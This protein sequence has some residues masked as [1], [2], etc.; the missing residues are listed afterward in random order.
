MLFHSMHSELHYKLALALVPQIGDVHARIL[1]SHFEDAQSIFS[2]PKEKLEKLEGIGSVRARAI[3]EFRDF[4]KVEKELAFMEQS[5]VRPIFLSDPGYPRRLQQCFDAPA[6]LFYK[7]SADLNA[8]RMVAVVG[9][10]SQTEYGR[11]FTLSLIE[12]LASEEIVVVSG[13]AFGIDATAHRAALDNGLATIGV[14]GHG[15]DKVY[16]YEHR[17]LAKEIVQQN[18]GMLTEF[19]SGTTPERHHF[20]LRNRI[21][22]G[23][24]DATIVVETHSRGGSMITAKLADSYNRDVFA[25][26]GR[27]TDVKS[28]GCNLLIR[29]NI[30]QMITC[31]GDLKEIMG[32][33][34]T[35]KTPKKQKELSF[36]YLC[37]WQ[38]TPR[39]NNSLKV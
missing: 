28:S 19:F 32:W 14:V 12:E 6:I 23:L 24:C 3:K 10:R 38:Q 9:T 34:K 26:P 7:G 30:A 5:G 20:P 8:S 2:A 22:A 37:T 21:V 29:R 15:L 17:G 1:V 39:Q 25:V 18:G 36:P 13:L 35:R 33:E 4:E 11:Q 31:A 16:P 27:T